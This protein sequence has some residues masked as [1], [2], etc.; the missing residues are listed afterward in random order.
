[1]RM[2][3]ARGDETGGDSGITL[4]ESCGLDM[5]LE[6]MDSSYHKVQ[7]ANNLPAPLLHSHVTRTIHVARTS[8]SGDSD[9]E[10]LKT[11]R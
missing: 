10:C 6:S 9:S 8:A 11:L 5:G 7:K 3:R 4:S 1:M 2:R